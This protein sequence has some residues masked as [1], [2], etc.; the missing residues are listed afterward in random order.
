V[1]ELVSSAGL[2][3][4][5]R[6]YR[7]LPALN[8]GLRDVEAVGVISFRPALSRRYRLRQVRKTLAVGSI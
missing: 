8:Y 3:P 2:I 4:E 1:S 5:I 7:A 6:V